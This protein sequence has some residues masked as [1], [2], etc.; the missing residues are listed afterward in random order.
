MN[1][2]MM[3]S[4]NDDVN[5][6]Y[7]SPRRAEAARQTRKLIREAAARLFV[8][9]GITATTMRQIAAAAGVAERTVYTA[10]PTK[11]ALFHEVSAARQQADFGCALLERAGE[12]IM[13]AIE[14]SG[15]DPDM[16]E[17]STRAAAETAKNM[18]TIAQTWERNGLLRD[19]LT[20]NDAGAILHTLNSAQVHQLFRR[21]GWDVD[22]Y[23]DWLTDA[24][25][26]TVLRPP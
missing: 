5:R 19:G 9:Q 2:A 26:S 23:R 10:F 4:M 21:Q 17:F 8:E 25:L 18:L 13:A 20:A 22:R 24:I 3:H 7:R 16:R 1:D 11:T 14:S 12:L 15:A 6:V